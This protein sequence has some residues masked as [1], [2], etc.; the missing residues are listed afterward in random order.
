MADA[1][2]KRTAPM[3]IRARWN[4]LADKVILEYGGDVYSGLTEAYS[5]DIRPRLTPDTACN[6]VIIISR[7]SKSFKPKPA[8]ALRRA[9]DLT[10]H[11]NRV[12]AYR[13]ARRAPA[14]LSLPTRLGSVT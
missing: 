10:G 14:I 9:G 1:N 2:N 6:P 5:I 11:L 7:R 12:F 3:T 4:R 8:D 13:P